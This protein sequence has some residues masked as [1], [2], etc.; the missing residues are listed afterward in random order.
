MPEVSLHVPTPLRPYSDGRSDVALEASSVAE[1]LDRLQAMYP[2]LVQ[3]IR[4]RD[5]DLRPYVNVFVRQTDIRTLD[6]LATAL[7]DGDE[8]VVMPSVAGG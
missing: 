7:E 5:D 3:H 2:V 1:L 6:G 4:T 8:V